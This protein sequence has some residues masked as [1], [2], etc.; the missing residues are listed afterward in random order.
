MLL[1]LNCV[2]M[3]TITCPAVTP[4]PWQRRMDELTVPCRGT[5]GC[6]SCPAV[7]LVAA[8]L[9]FRG[10]WQISHLI[11]LVFQLL[12][13]GSWVP[14]ANRWRQYTS[15]HTTF[16]YLHHRIIG[17]SL[18]L[19]VSERLGFPHFEYCYLVSACLWPRKRFSP[20]KKNRASGR[21]NKRYWFNLIQRETV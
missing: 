17:L 4:S 7:S 21:Q 6:Y 16:T 20:R 12:T 3:V 8:K 15:P 19:Y 1:L 13:I 2:V 10:V 9:S 18:L 5:S 11:N 14:A